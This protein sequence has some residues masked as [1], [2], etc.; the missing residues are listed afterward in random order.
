MDHSIEDGTAQATFDL[1]VSPA[2]CLQLVADEVLIAIDLRFR[3]RTSVIATGLFPRLAS[4]V[5]KGSKDLIPRQRGCLTIAMLLD[6]SVFAQRDEGPN[7]GTT[8]RR[9]QGVENLLFV[10]RTIP[11]YRP[12]RLVDLG[13][14]RGDLRGIIDPMGRQR[15]GDHL[16][17]GLMDPHMQFAP[18]PP[19]GPAVL[20]DFPLALTVDFQAGRIYH[21]VHRFI[22]ALGRQHHR[23]VPLAT[24]QGR[25]IR[26]RQFQLHQ[27]QK[28]LDKAL[29]LAQRQP[30][31]HP[32][33]Q[34][35][36]N[37]WI[38]IYKLSTP[39]RRPL[40]IPLLPQRIVQPDRQATAGD[41]RPIIRRPIFDPIHRFRLDRGRTARYFAHHRL[42][43]KR[44]TCFLLEI[45]NQSN[46][47]A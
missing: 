43:G 32:H 38:R 12:H 8:P 26:R 23:Q 27:V 4:L 13:Q 7:R 39:L 10:I 16:T 1:L 46:R 25:V 14:Q 6:L 47:R 45:T 18:S 34:H 35:P 3:Q 21:Q 42:S 29:R 9:G 17:G 33:R 2:T 24:R 41:Q 22:G 11:A 44:G 5:S 19:F 36:F 20:T 40:I 37:R 28:R 15:L 31:Q 30:K